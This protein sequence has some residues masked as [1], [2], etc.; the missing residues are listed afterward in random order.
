[1]HVLKSHEINFSKVVSDPFI[2]KLFDIVTEPNMNFHEASGIPCPLCPKKF[3]SGRTL[4]DHH[5]QV[6]D[7]T[8]HIPCPHA[9]CQFTSFQPYVLKQHILKKHTKTVKYECDECSFSTY[10]GHKAVRM[11]KKKMH[12]VGKDLRPFQCSECEK[13]YKSKGNLADHLFEVH[14]IVYQ[15]ETNQGIKSSHL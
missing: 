4:S 12:N 5:K 11:H 13:N 15:Y 7:K 8:N 3:S 1:M 14:N 2:L 10:S 6:H 9:P